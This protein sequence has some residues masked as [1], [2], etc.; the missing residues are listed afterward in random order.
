VEVLVSSLSCLRSD[1]IRSCF[2][3]LLAACSLGLAATAAAQTGGPTVRVRVNAF[4][5]F[6]FPGSPN[7][8]LTV[9]AGV[10]LVIQWDAT[11]Q[12]GTSIARAR[13]GWNIVNPDDD[14][15]W[16]QDWCAVCPPVPVRTFNAGVQR[17]FL[18]VEDSAANRTRAEIGIVVSQ[19]AV[20]P[21]SWTAWKRR[22]EP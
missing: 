5:E 15:Q 18:E 7:A 22:L 19:L 16:D 3:A 1:A 2:V 10:P 21:S 8:Q 17:F 12:P 14:Q 13:Y 6:T 4:P 9:L 11:P 20:E